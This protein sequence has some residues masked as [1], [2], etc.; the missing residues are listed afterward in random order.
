M[1][2]PVTLHPAWAQAVL[3]WKDEVKGGG[4]VCNNIVFNAH[5]GNDIRD[6]QAP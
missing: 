2:A 5:K 1:A 6:I 4:I 3:W